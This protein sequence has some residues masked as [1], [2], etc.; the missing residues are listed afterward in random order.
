MKARIGVESGKNS[1]SVGNVRPCSEGKVYQ[2][3]NNGDIGVLAHFQGFCFGLGAHGGGEMT[4]RVKRGG[5]RLAI[6]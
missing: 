3:P 5:Y 1:G 6:L 4:S 2:Q